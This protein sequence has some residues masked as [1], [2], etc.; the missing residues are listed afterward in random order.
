MQTRKRRRR[1]NIDDDKDITN[2]ALSKPMVPKYKRIKSKTT[3]LEPIKNNIN[4]NNE[5]IIK[6]KCQ[7]LLNNARVIESSSSSTSTT[8]SID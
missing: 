4:T 7:L 3:S 2:K 5:A 8:H 1:V 6:E